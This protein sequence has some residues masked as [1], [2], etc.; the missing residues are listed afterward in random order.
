MTEIII[1]NAVLTK[2]GNISPVWDASRNNDSPNIIV[3]S[4]SHKVWCDY[5]Y[6][7]NLDLLTPNL[8]IEITNMPFKRPYVFFDTS[9]SVTD[10]NIFY[11]GSAVQ[12]FQNLFIVCKIRN[13]NKFSHILTY[14]ANYTND[15]SSSNKMFWS[16][17]SLSIYHNSGDNHTFLYCRVG[18]TYK[19]VRITNFD[20]DTLHTFAIENADTAG[21]DVRF[22]FNDHELCTI[23]NI[24][25]GVGGYTTYN[26]N[27]VSNSARYIQFGVGQIADLNLPFNSVLQTEQ[28]AVSQCYAIGVGQLTDNLMAMIFDRYNYSH[29][30][31]IITQVQSYTIDGTL[32]TIFGTTTDFSGNMQIL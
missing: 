17:I 8:E 19:T 11:Y 22:M 28:N 30:N 2:A 23:P 9:T 3:N 1:R 12:Q 16:G 32:G 25:D 29:V 31:L 21:Q 7:G 18:T 13:N 14:G 5:N 27:M 10:G 20:F 26:C 6:T 24:T 15:T 4:V